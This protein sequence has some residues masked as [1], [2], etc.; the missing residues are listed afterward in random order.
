MFEGRRI[1]HHLHP[2]HGQ[3][4]HR[5]GDLH[6]ETINVKNGTLKGGKT[7]NGGISDNNDNATIFKLYQKKETCTESQSDKVSASVKFT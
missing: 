2:Q 6:L 7:K 4:A 1:S 5:G 3:K